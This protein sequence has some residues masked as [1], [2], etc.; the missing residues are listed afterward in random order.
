MPSLLRS[1]GLIPQPPYE[2]SGLVYHGADV[3]EHVSTLLRGLSG[4]LTA[5][6]IATEIE[7][8]IDAFAERV[9]TECGLDPVL[10]VSPNLAVWAKKP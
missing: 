8:D 1:V 10:T 5:H 6:G 9:R 4:V 3:V 2:L 7:L